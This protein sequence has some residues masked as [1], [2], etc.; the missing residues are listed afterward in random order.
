MA[1]VFLSDP[2]RVFRE[3][4]GERGVGV[5]DDADVYWGLMFCG[6][7]IENQ[8]QVYLGFADNVTFSAHAIEYAVVL[9]SILDALG[10]RDDVNVVFDLLRKW[11]EEHRTR[12]VPEVPT[13]QPNL[14]RT[15][16]YDEWSD[17]D[18][19]ADESTEPADEPLRQ[20]EHPAQAELRSQRDPSPEE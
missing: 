12:F 3:W 20:N 15:T 6:V 18:A 11:E 14:V 5:P 1:N 9:E 19:I 17:R 10:I 7:V 16:A 13:Y 2:R 8:R 4:C